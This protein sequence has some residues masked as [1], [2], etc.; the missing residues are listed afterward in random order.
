MAYLSVGSRSPVRVRPV[1]SR[2]VSSR[3]VSSRLV[4]TKPLAFH[5]L[6]MS[7]PSP[8]VSQRPCCSK[9]ADCRLGRGATKGP[10][11]E[12]PETTGEP[13]RTTGNRGEPQG[14]HLEPRESN[15]EPVGTVQG[16]DR[17]GQKGSRREIEREPL[18]G[19]R[20]PDIASARPQA[21]WRSLP[22][23][24]FCCNRICCGVWCVCASS[25]RGAGRRGGA[26]A[27][28]CLIT[29]AANDE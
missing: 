16:A 8:S 26:A 10:S 13:R 19:G 9:G 25:R 6:L 18:L 28:R 24:P 22:D 23:A 11:W 12:Q 21:E 20:G 4:L 15:R 7:D 17:Q 3:L 27:R 29:A 14:N 2:L 5:L 1:S